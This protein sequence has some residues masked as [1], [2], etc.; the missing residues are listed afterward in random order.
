MRIAGNVR[1]QRLFRFT[2]WS[3]SVFRV[4]RSGVTARRYREYLLKGREDS[5]FDSRRNHV[6]HDSAMMPF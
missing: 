5:G 6:N 3:S 4:I 1:P 2:T